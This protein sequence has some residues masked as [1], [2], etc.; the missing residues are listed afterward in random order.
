MKLKIP[1]YQLSEVLNMMAFKG[2]SE[3]DIKTMMDL[4]ILREHYYRYN[5]TIFKAGEITEELGIVIKGRVIVENV[6]YWGSKSILSSALPG[7]VFGETYAL[8]G[9]K[10]MI[11][12][13]ATEP[14]IVFLLNAQDIMSGKYNSYPWHLQM[15]KNLLLLSS[16]RSLTLSLHI[17]Y[18][19]PKKIRERVSYY[20]S[21]LASSLGTTVQHAE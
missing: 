2:I 19:K 3:A 6:D 13:R 16:R 11:D 20:L 8:S 1:Q 10:L 9:H 12:A 21:G 5:S 17:F 14:T 4:R 15:L 18:I 7:K